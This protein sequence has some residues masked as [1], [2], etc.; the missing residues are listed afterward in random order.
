M[1]DTTNNPPRRTRVISA[2]SVASAAAWEPPNV[3]AGAAARPQGDVQ[4]HKWREGQGWTGAP[5]VTAKQIEQI[6]RQAYDEGFAQGRAA[7]LAAV[8]PPIETVLKALDSPLGEFDE[9]VLQEIVQLVKAVSRQLVRRELKAE[10]GEIMAVVREAL[11]ALP[12]ASRAAQLKL[13]PE[14]AKLVREALALSEGDRPWKI[15][16][17]PTQ[18]RGG[19]RVETETSLID[20]SLETR[21]NAVISR[22][23]GGSRDDDSPG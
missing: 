1:S 23:L 22:L 14:D 5:M 12:S 10:P 8:K 6:Q 17:D 13:H 11:G 20:A 19:C 2:D 15:V 21:L 3:G 7:G 16:D 4:E 18:T 9:A